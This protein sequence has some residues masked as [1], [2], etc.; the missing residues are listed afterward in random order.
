[1]AIPKKKKV[2]EID[3][4]QDHKSKPTPIDAAVA[5]REMKQLAKNAGMLPENVIQ[6][7]PAT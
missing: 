4:W 2:E 7:D 5:R 1:M 3:M 6:D